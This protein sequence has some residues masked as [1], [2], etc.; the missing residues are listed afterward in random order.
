MIAESSAT[1][2]ATDGTTLEARIAVPDGASAGIVICHP[3]P[4]YGGDMENP[5]VVR[6]AEVCGDLGLATLRLN[7]RGVGH[8]EGVHDNGR[9]ERLDVV[10]AL[11]HLTSRLEPPGAT[12][13][14]GYSFG[15]TVAAN[16]ARTASDL[17]RLALIAPP[18]GLM[19][20]APFAPLVG[21]QGSLLIVV[22]A[23]D[24]YC[25]P[26]A[27]ARMGQTFPRAV[28]R[29][30]DGA[31]HFFF[32]KLFPLGEILAAW[33]RPFTLPPSVTRKAGRGRGTG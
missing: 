9:G 4:L 27:I 32:G 19:G 2:V 21:F 30:I 15:A 33:A 22:G 18:V 29:V 31:N 13:L 14:A 26:K 24:D 1:V 6:V 20:E 11:A 23:L 28:I 16:V 17:A 8:S 12:S 25:P 5:V 10:A 7:F 3:H